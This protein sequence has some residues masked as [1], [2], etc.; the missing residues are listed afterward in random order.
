MIAI[1]LLAECLS[2]N[3]TILIFLLKDLRKN[4]E[5]ETITILQVNE[6]YGD[7]EELDYED[8]NKLVYLEQ[9]LK[10]CLRLHPPVQ[11]QFRRN[12]YNEVRVEELLIPKS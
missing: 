8:L 11:M 6:V 1:S 3:H 7:K 2:I 10:E 9:C 5:I 12:T 4:S